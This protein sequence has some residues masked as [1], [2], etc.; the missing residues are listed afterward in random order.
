MAKISSAARAILDDV[1]A[2]FQLSD[3]QLVEITNSM[4]GE[5]NTGLREAGHSVAMV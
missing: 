3:G 1:S 4:V 2:P 5:F